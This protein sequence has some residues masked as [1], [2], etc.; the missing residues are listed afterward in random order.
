MNIE[1]GLFDSA[2][3]LLVLKLRLRNCWSFE[4]EVKTYEFKLRI[5]P[6]VYVSWGKHH[7]AGPS[8]VN[9]YAQYKRERA[10]SAAVLASYETK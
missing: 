8:I 3:R 6:L 1:L 4:F 7:S 9:L 10:R 5:Y 2:C